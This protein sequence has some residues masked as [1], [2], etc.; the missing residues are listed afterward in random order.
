MQDNNIFRPLKDQMQTII[1]HWQKLLSLRAERDMVLS[2]IQKEH[3]LPVDMNA[4]D[5][6]YQLIKYI[7]LTS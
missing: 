1:Q 6:N 5:C 3:R 2:S 4:E 7:F